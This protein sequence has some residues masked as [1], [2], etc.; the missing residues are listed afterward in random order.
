MVSEN[1]CKL[2]QIYKEIRWRHRIWTERDYSGN[3]M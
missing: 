3:I 1:N 2:R